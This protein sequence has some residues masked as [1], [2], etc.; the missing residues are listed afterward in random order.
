MR[1]VPS[2]YMA[3]A[4]A[5]GADPLP[6]DLAASGLPSLAW[7]DLPT[8]DLPLFERHFYGSPALVERIARLHGA[9]ADEVLIASGTSMANFL[10]A[11]AL[12]SP[13]DRVVVE[14]PTYE[15]LRAT[16]ETLSAAIETLPRPFA[17]G[18]Q[19]DP[20]DLDA[21]VRGARMV[22]LTNLHNPSGVELEPDRLAAIARLA[23][24][25][26]AVLLVDEVYMDFLA[27]PR[28]ATRAPHIVVTGSLTKVYG[29]TG[30][31]AGWAVGPPDLIRRAYQVKDLISVID[32]FPMTALAARVLDRRD[33]LRAAALAAAATGRRVLS[34]W[35][36]EHGL[37]WVEPAGGII[38]A[39]RLPD[40]LSGHTLSDHLAARHATRVVPGEFF[41]LPGF[42]RIGFGS[43]AA[44]LEAGLARVAQG[45]AELS[46]A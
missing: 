27:V 15:P 22:V 38:G 1:L 10:V 34:R 43:P 26:G 44:K 21:R 14:E 45:V 36:A 11:A 17:A 7:A 33:E 42:V 46:P 5:A 35:V 39:V 24:R 41:G 6:F 12:L 25:A 28:H 4:K 18:F 32:P 20:T 16:L 30:L 3:W 29:L 31:R 23:E 37:A 2:R 19:P 8:A 9:R 40:G 13:G